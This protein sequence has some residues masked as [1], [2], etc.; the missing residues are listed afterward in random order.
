MIELLKDVNARCGWDCVLTSYDGWRMHFSSGSCP[1]YATPLVT[2]SG[3]SYLSCP[4]EFRHPVFRLAS[5]S[6]RNLIGSHV[7][8]DD[9][10]YVI[11]IEA[12]TMAS[13]KPDVYL[14]AA[15]SGEL[16]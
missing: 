11:A 5:T 12:E 8:L 1:E 15:Q 4:M 2:F 16:A 6:E 10:D 13:D 3:V 14:I 7:L 9:T